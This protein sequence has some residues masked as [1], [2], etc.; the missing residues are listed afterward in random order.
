VNTLSIEELVEHAKK[1]DNTA[2]NK[3]VKLWYTRIYNYSFKF[4]GEHDTAMEVT[5]K[6]FISLHQHLE[7]LKEAR[8]F[9]AWV[10]QIATNYCKEEVRKQK[11]KWVL[12]F[13]SFKK[14]V[15]DEIFT[16]VKTS[17][18]GPEHL[19]EEAEIN[20]LIIKA[21]K[22]LPEEQRTVVIM[23]EYE[24]L[25]FKEIAEILQLSENTVKS[26]MYYGLKHLKEI[27][28]KWNIKKENFYYEL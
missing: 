10:Y 17:E 22:K 26:R 5:Q 12:P 16:D 15:D 8:F 14:Q 18:K 6:T 20:K 24:C 25:K 21:L 9:K 1:G 13:V 23:K 28:D 2:F 7:K 19:I 3:L 4:L 27:F 11:R